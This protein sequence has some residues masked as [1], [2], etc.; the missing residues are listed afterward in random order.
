[1]LKPHIH[2]H[3]HI[4]T[5]TH[6]YTHQ[7][8]FAKQRNSLFNEQVELFHPLAQNSTCLPGKMIFVVVVCPEI[9]WGW[10]KLMFQP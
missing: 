3:I 2:A 10:V 9:E 1:M 8:S 7:K 4:C 6:T 5:H